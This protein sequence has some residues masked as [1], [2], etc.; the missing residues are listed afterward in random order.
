L[1]GPLFHRA[2]IALM[3]LGKRVRPHLKSAISSLARARRTTQ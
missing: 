1:G 2:P 3:P